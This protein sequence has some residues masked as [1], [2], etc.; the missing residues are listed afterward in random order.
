MNVIY[1]NLRCGLREFTNPFSSHISLPHDHSLAQ[2]ELKEK[3][4]SLESNSQRNG[5][6]GKETDTP[7]ERATAILYTLK[8]VRSH[9]D[10][11]Q[12]WCEHKL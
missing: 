9:S 4:Y 7:F 12:S 8:Q 2:N 10:I 11:V 1:L 3:C 5:A 6:L